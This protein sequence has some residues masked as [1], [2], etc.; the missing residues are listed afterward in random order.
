MRLSKPVLVF[1][2]AVAC[3]PA[4]SQ[5]PPAPEA[6]APSSSTP[7]QS[8]AALVASASTAS[9]SLD[10]EARSLVLAWNDALDS[11]NPAAL[12]GLYA[13]QVR[14]YGKSLLRSAVVASKRAALSAK[15]T[16]HQQI[17]GDISTKVEGDAVTAEFQKRSGSATKMLDVRARLELR[18]GDG[19]RLVITAETDDV[20]EHRRDNPTSCHT[21]TDCPHGQICEFVAGDTY[22]CEEPFL[23]K[24]CPKGQIFLKSDGECWTACKTD[25]DCPKDMCCLSD[26]NAQEPVCMGRCP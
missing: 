6:A 20:T 14:F 21:D 16:F 4:S 25:A 8:V 7:P 23:P 5:E 12:E 15:S 19:G 3:H 22:V 17:V 9:T 26:Y 13:D 1:L 24:P 11:H 2:C 10:R 18:R